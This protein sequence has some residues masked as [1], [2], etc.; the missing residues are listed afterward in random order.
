M[1]ELIFN[2]NECK[3]TECSAVNSFVFEALL[4][5]VDFGLSKQFRVPLLP[6]C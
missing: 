5:P 1:M 2:S 6:S 3:G 4:N